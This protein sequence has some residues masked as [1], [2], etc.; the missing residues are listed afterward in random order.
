[1]AVVLA[2][3]SVTGCAGYTEFATDIGHSSAT[4]NGG[5][6]AGPSGTVVY[7]EYWPTA[8]PGAKLETPRRAIGAAA[9][10]PFEARVT[11]LDADTSYSFR[12][13]G[14]EDAV[15]ICAQTRRFVTG[16]DNVF[17]WGKHPHGVPAS[18][19]PSP[20]GRSRRTPSRA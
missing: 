14:Q 7:F 20:W 18:L 4:L 3:L 17:A 10:G 12:L 15:V 5:G 13:C 6:V 1:M 16:A 2:G 11:D 19:R 9:R 8:E